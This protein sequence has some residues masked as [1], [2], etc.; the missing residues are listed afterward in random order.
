M[1]LQTR[2]IIVKVFHSAVGYKRIFQENVNL[3]SP[4]VRREKSDTRL[5]ISLF[6]RKDDI[7]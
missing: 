4:L 5:Q 3:K 1:N 6:G 2:N 7:F